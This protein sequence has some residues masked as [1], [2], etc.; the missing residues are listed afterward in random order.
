MMTSPSESQEQTT[1]VNYLRWRWKL[2]PDAP[3]IAA[4]PNGGYRNPREGTNLRRQGVL[5]GI[6]DLVL[7]FSEGRTCW[8]EMKAIKGTVS[9]E[10]KRMHAAL[11][12]LGHEVMIAYGS[13]DAI[14]QLQERG[15]LQ[16]E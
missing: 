1:L 8:I 4:I 6:P 14:R 16:P 9:P 12:K 10:Q 5:K 11:E 3:V 15:Y 13:N 2:A 7:I